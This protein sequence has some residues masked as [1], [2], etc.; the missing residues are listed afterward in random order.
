MASSSLRARA[1]ALL[2]MLGGAAARQQQ[3]AVALAASRR[4][5]ADDASLKKTVL[6]DFHVGLGGERGVDWTVWVLEKRREGATSSRP[7]ART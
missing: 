7:H 2:R 6:Y 3:P 4:L 5:F 1:P